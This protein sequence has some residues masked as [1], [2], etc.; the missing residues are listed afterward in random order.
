[1][2]LVFLLMVGYKCGT[3]VADD[4][5]MQIFLEF[6]FLMFLRK[7][8]RI[9][10][11]LRTVFMCVKICDLGSKINLNFFESCKQ[12][13]AKLPVKLINLVY[14]CKLRPFTIQAVT[15]LKGQKIC[16]KPIVIYI[17]KNGKTS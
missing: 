14:L 12:D 1:M 8:R 15:L 2:P 3:L 16:G 13:T 6:V 11:S 10:I 17:F 4:L 9:H 5:P 7:I